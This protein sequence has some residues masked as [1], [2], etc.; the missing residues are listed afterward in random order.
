MLIKGRKEVHVQAEMHKQRKNIKTLDD[1]IEVLLELNKRTYLYGRN[2]V[3]Y[4]DLLSG[5]AIVCLILVFYFIDTVS[6]SDGLQGI[7]ALFLV[8]SVR[9]AIVYAGELSRL[10]GRVLQQRVIIEK[11]PYK[12]ISKERH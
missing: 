1:D 5:L 12:S 4:A 10:L 3:I 7:A 6:D 2:S 11:N 9:F 8:F